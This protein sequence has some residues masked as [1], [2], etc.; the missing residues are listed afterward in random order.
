MAAKNIQTGNKTAKDN[1]STI[2]CFFSKES[3]SMH[4]NSLNTQIDSYDP[5]T[6]LN[7]N[8]L[9][10][11]SKQHL[12]KDGSND[13]KSNLEKRLGKN[14]KEI[15]KKEEEEV[16][17]CKLYQNTCDDKKILSPRKILSLKVSKGFSSGSKNESSNCSGGIFNTKSTNTDETNF[18]D[19]YVSQRDGKSKPID[20]ISSISSSSEDEMHVLKKR[21]KS[22]QSPFEDKTDNVKRLLVNSITTNSS[23]PN[24]TNQTKKKHVDE[25]EAMLIEDGDLD[26]NKEETIHVPYYLENFK[27]IISQVLKDEEYDALFDNDDR[28]VVET[29]HSLSECSQ[30]LYVRLFARKLTWRIESKIKY[31]QIAEDLSDSFQELIQAGFGLSEEHLTE[32]S[33]VIALLP[34]AELKTVAK[35]FH[36]NCLNLKKSQIV[37]LLVNHCKKTSATSMLFSLNGQ[38]QAE[39]AMIKRSKKLLGRCF[40]LV[41]SV[42]AVFLRFLA[43]FSL[44]NT[45]LDED[46]AGSLSSKLFQMLQVNIGNVVFPQYRIC[47]KTKIF[48][49]RTDFIKYTEVMLLENEIFSKL[50]RKDWSAAFEVYVQAKTIYDENIEDLDLLKW[51]RNLP[52]FLRHCTSGYVFARLLFQGVELLQRQKN[53]K[54]ACQVLQDLLSQ[55]VYACSHRGRWY[56]RLTLN[57][58]QHL[59]SPAKALDV[60]ETAFQDVWVSPYYRLSLFL[61]AEK[62]AK[63]PKSKWEKRFAKME[64]I[65]IQKLPETII[66]GKTLPHSLPGIKYQFL[67]EESEGEITLCNVEQL[68]LKHY[69]NNGY[70]K[71]VH[72]ESSIIST[73]FFL[74]FWEIIFIDIPDVFRCPFQTCPLDMMTSEFYRNRQ[75]RLEARLQQI[76]SA[77]SQDLCDIMAETWNTNFGITCAINWSNW[78]SI[79][80]LQDLV[81]CIG[82]S[83][84]A[85][86]F[87]RYAKNPRHSRSGFPDLTLWNVETKKFKIC[88][89]KGPGDRLS[90]KQILWIN[91]LLQFGVDVEV[92]YVKPVGA[93]K[94]PSE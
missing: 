46:T 33:D 56:E 26:A 64:Q 18:E 65:T 15:E 43:L 69:Q 61:R 37:Q 31:P 93:K 29:F 12:I 57:L 9:R 38:K 71:G 1:Q 27:M 30:K 94:L 90:T 86:I 23:N 89:V 55:D 80:E 40:K 11:L 48:R 32:L 68:V 63:A 2:L 58:D 49:H 16:T 21:N 4:P 79:E 62:I 13:L 22:L 35:S 10:K 28:K 47:K 54:E 70:P 36:H 41:E 17:T 25:E 20:L 74:F 82:G 45:T 52:I 73:L 78:V 87:G 81:S 92:C 34:V 72:A 50:E 83:I 8:S 85:A 6:Q 5:K 77:S 60:I 39:H 88:E 42:C 76:S 7:R 67:T 14:D 91:D 44:A 66:K 19:S 84:L 53:Y 75:S 59:K 51:D 24:E 3:A